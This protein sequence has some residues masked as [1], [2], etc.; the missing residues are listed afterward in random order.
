MSE[1]VC[2][3]SI[4]YRSLAVFIAGLLM[5]CTNPEEQS[6][7]NYAFTR[8]STSGYSIT[9]DINKNGFIEISL[10]VP[11][12]NLTNFQKQSSSISNMTGGELEQNLFDMI[13]KAVQSWA[14]TLVGENGWQQSQIAVRRN[15]SMPSNC[16]RDSYAAWRCEGNRRLTF[17]FDSTCA[18]SAASLDTRTVTLC[19][20]LLRLERDVVARVILHEVGHIWGLGD[21]YGEAGGRAVANQPSGIMNDLYQVQGLTEDDK[22]GS[23]ALWSYLFKGGQPC[24]DGYMAI[25]S[26][27]SSMNAIVCQPHNRTDSVIA[28]NRPQPAQNVG[29]AAGCS[30]ADAGKNNGWGWNESTKTSCPPR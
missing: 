19:G 26:G 29:S 6:E 5:S 20:D 12:Q 30:Y 4:N 10:A 17:V 3:Y 24:R 1:R 2:F 14:A 7:I 23:K 21:T 11:S 27:N 22:S 9:N 13:E 28:N 25:P 18:R 15:L 16:A 8:G